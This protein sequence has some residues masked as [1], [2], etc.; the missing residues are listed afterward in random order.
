MPSISI[1]I[2]TYNRSDKLT[3]LLNKLTFLADNHD[4]IEILV[5]DNNSTDCTRESVQILM[6]QYKNL[7]YIFVEEQGLSAARNGGV[8]N[9]TGEV[10]AFL[11]DDVRLHDNYMKNLEL[12]LE[13]NK[14]IFAFGGRILQDWG[15]I[16]R[17]SWLGPPSNRTLA[18]PLGNHDLGDNIGYYG[19]TGFYAFAGANFWI[20]KDV[21]DKVGGFRH[22]LGVKGKERL[23]GEDSDLC[24]RI[25][26]C[27]YKAI[28]C[29]NVIVYH[30][31]ETDKL[32]KTYF[33]I[34]YAASGKSLAR[35][36]PPTSD[37][38]CFC[39][40]PRYLYVQLLSKYLYWLKS[41]IGTDPFTKFYWELQAIFTRSLIIEYQFMNK[42][43]QM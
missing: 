11:D 27:G 36:N 35:M 8:I 3:S 6:R 22:D 12:S 41:M 1:I 19:E 28:Y 17:P 2:C 37:I 34:W 40:A 13:Q 10:Y 20:Y 39:G 33:R 24:F 31:V 4:H 14:D 29:P 32:N 38:K 42:Y 9:A 26:R 18:G 7:K 16:N 43:K 25:I 5:V 23:L 21:F 15:S 30:P